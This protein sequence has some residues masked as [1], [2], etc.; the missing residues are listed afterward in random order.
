[1]NDSQSHRFLQLEDD[2]SRL[3]DELAALKTEATALGEARLTL[4]NASAAFLPLATR[5]DTAA[6]SVA[7]LATEAQ[8]VSADK[9]AQHLSALLGQLAALSDTVTTLGS[10]FRN[11]IQGVRATL[12]DVDRTLGA[13]RQRMDAAIEQLRGALT[14]TA[15]LARSD[16][17]M[18][19]TDIQGLRDAM[20]RDQQALRSDF[21]TSSSAVTHHLTQLRRLTVATVAVGSVALL[22]LL[23]V[24]LRV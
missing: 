2:A 5:L 7:L 24:L 22:L 18:F 1:M 9:L 11:D 23:V 15:E 6:R 12:D 21:A 14:V 20:T 8:A 10:S 13:H 3:L 4:Q 16:R 19:R 17:D